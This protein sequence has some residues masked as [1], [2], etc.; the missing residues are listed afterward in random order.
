MEAQSKRLTLKRT[1]FVPPASIWGG[2]LRRAASEKAA[3]PEDPMFPFRATDF[4]DVAREQQRE[5]KLRETEAG[6]HK[7]QACTLSIEKRVDGAAQKRK[8]YERFARCAS[9]S[10][11]GIQF[12]FTALASVDREHQRMRKQLK[13]ER[14]ALRSQVEAEAMA[15]PV[16][17]PARKRKHRLRF[18]PHVQ[19]IPYGQKPNKSWPE[20][21]RSSSRIIAGVCKLFAPVES[22]P[23]ISRPH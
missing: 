11:L 3:F 18:S 1:P 19:E 15:Q 8:L 22:I 10:D 2:T 17:T 9:I 4:A 16:K 6:A 7:S 5:P 20:Q 13:S 12:R 21:M 14:V 23:S